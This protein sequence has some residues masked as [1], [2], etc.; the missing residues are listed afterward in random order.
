MLTFAGPGTELGS[1]ADGRY[2]LLRSLGGSDAGADRFEC[3]G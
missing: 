2:T 1:L 3:T